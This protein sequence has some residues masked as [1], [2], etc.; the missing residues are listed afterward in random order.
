MTNGAELPIS[1][2][3]AFDPEICTGCG[4]CEL[5]CSSRHEG[6]SNPKLSCITIY[7]NSLDGE[8]TCDVCNQCQYPGCLSACT[9]NA[10]LV[11]Q[12]TGAR[13]IDDETCVDCGLCYKACPFTPDRAMIKIRVVDGQER[14]FKCDLCKD[15]P[16]GP[17]CVQFCPTKALTFVTAAARKRPHKHEEDSGEGKVVNIARK[18]FFKPSGG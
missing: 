6:I 12:A 3:I 16:Y 13:Y 9:A 11:D 18:D 5:V 1:G 4:T 2:V 8:Y 7:N 14:Y 15:R 10:I 17:L